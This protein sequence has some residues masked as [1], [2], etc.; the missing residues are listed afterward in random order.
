MVLAANAPIQLVRRADT[1]RGATG[2]LLA[3]SAPAS[4]SWKARCWQEAG[5]PSPHQLFGQVLLKLGMRFSFAPSPALAENP[6]WAPRP[7]IAGALR[8]WQR[9]RLGNLRSPRLPLGPRRQALRREGRQAD[10]RHRLVAHRFRALSLARLRR[11]GMRLGQ[12]SW[13]TPTPPLPSWKRRSPCAGAC[14]TPPKALLSQIRFNLRR[15]C[16]RKGPPHQRLSKP[17]TGST[18]WTTRRNG[19]QPLSVAFESAW[20]PRVR[21]AE[22]PALTGRTPR[23]IVSGLIRQIVRRCFFSDR[24]VQRLRKCWSGKRLPLA[25]CRV[26]LATRTTRAAATKRTASSRSLS[27]L[28]R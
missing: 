17:T 15:A 23:P 25:M 18:A 3:A 5:R 7:I 28:V 6:L 26:P 9:H 8:A 21:K 14:G 16:Q 22:L 2:R 4:Q 1:A 27:V 12:H 19:D 20:L 11:L 13:A 10:P 24:E